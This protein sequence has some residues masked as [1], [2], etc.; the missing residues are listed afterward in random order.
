PLHNLV[1]LKYD[2]ALLG[3]TP[4]KAA[5]IH[6]VEPKAGEDLWVI[7]FQ[8]DQALQ[9]R[10]TR[11][12]TTEPLRLPLS[13]TFRFRDA[14]LETWL[15]EDAVNG[16]GV[17]VDEKGRVRGLWSSFAYQGGRQLAQLY[18]GMPAHYI[19]E[20]LRLAAGETE[21][22]SLETELFFMPLSSARKL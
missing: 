16:D 1:V 5:P 11:M 10:A 22:R 6:A 19:K 17:L 3:D 2:P 12:Q 18:S 21:L 7:G 13:S 20:V 15:L 4:V 9:S 14:N 8:P